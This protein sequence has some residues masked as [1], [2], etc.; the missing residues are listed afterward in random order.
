M[1]EDTLSSMRSE[2][3]DICQTQGHGGKGQF[4]LQEKRKGIQDCLKW[5]K[6]EGRERIRE[7]EIVEQKMVQSCSYLE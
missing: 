1:W 6:G 2:G 7:G 4:A 3:M 5:G